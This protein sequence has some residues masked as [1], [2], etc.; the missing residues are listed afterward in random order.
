[1]SKPLK[2]ESQSGTKV[3]QKVSNIERQKELFLVSKITTNKEEKQNF[4]EKKKKP[5]Q[6]VNSKV[7]A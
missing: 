6:N 5:T 7:K 1:M 3:N 4:K 2:I